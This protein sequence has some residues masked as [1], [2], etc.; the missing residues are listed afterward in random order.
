MRYYRHT[1]IPPHLVVAGEPLPGG[2]VLHRLGRQDQAVVLAV[3]PRLVPS[4][5]EERHDLGHTL[6]LAERR[7]EARAGLDV[8]VLVLVWKR[9]RFI[10]T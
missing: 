7:L 6:L 1:A 4:L 5:V 2:D 8:D 3:S 9:R 10:R